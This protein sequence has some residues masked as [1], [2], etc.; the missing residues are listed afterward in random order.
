MV[1]FVKPLYLA[2]GAAFFS[3]Y[4]LDF[5]PHK[6]YSLKSIRTREKF[7]RGILTDYFKVALDIFLGICLI[8]IS[9]DN[10][11]IALIGALVASLPDFF[12]FLNI[13]LPKNKI[14]SALGEFHSAAHWV[15]NKKNPYAIL[16][17]F[18]ETTVILALFLFLL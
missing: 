7:G 6:D 9:A 12:D 5:L 1:K 13:F 11:F 10:L 14:L 3:H 18:I 15:E 2:L 17:I 8:A 16:S 4:L